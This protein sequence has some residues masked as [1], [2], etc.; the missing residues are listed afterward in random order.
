MLCGFLWG[1]IIFHKK[2]KY[3][4]YFSVISLFLITIAV[5]IPPPKKEVFIFT[6]PA[7]QPTIFVESEKALNTSIPSC[8]LT[9]P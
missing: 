8:S 9:K 4:R 7:L 3:V 1:G 5:N 6:K 2:L